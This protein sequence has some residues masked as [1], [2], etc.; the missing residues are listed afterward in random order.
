[1]FPNV[2]IIAKG[3]CRD[4]ERAVFSIREAAELHWLDAFGLIDND[5]RPQTE[6]DR[7]KEGGVY[8]TAVFS[9][10][11][12]YYYPEVQRRVAERHASTTGADFNSCLDKARSSAIAALTSHIQRLSERVP[13]RLIR[14]EFFAHIPN[15]EQISAATTVN[16]SIDVPRIVGEECARLQEALAA[17]D[18]ET[19]VSRYPVRETPAL[20]EIARKLGFQARDQYEGAVRKLLMDEV[21]ALTFVRS[22]FGTLAAD[23]AAGVGADAAPMN[24]ARA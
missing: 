4:V 8:A 17:G 12:V 1:M 5:R 19:V 23:I 3:S 18:L 16:V 15:K 20:D 24:I 10:E 11:G 2:S 6:I 7:L 9:V 13:E 14:K 22:L 21:D